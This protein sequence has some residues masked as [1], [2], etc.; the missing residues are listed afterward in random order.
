MLFGRSG[1]YETNAD[2]SAVL[3]NEET[4]LRASVEFEQC[5]AISM[6]GVYTESVQR[7]EERGGGDGGGG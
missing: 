4:R 3:R 2:C 1:A 6:R 5:L 7:C